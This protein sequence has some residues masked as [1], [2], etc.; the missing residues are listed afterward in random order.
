MKLKLTERHKN[1]AFFEVK[2]KPEEVV[3]ILLE[4]RQYQDGITSPRSV[5][6]FKVD[7]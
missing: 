4:W 2:G 3:P 5:A 6:G 1:G 7:D